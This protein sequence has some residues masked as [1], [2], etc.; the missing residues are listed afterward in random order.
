MTKT[1]KVGGMT[2]QGCANSVSRALER[3]PGVSRALV[4]LAAG[5]VS[6]EGTATAGDVRGAVEG[7]GF[8]F[9][10]AV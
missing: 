5:T 4:D 1:Y 3:Q 2:C 6:V 8:S 10:G 9:D 7:A